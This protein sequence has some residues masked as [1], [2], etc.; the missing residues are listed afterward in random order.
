[1][2]GLLTR[3][4]V[5]TLLLASCTTL[6]GP[7]PPPVAQTTDDCDTSGTRVGADDWR[8]A[9]LRCD[10]STVAARSAIYR[11][12]Y[13]AIVSE[14]GLLD[15]FSLASAFAVAGF[16]LFGAHEDNLRAA[17]LG[18]GSST[19]MRNGLN[20]SEQA[21]IYNAGARSMNCYA[22]EA[23][24]VIDG[25]DAGDSGGMASTYA[26]L[27]ELVVQAGYATPGTPD[28]ENANAARAAELAR[29]DAL[30]ARANSVRAELLTAYSAL[31]RFP[32]AM[33]VSWQAADGHIHDRL[34]AQTP[35]I[36]A[37]IAAVRALDAPD[38]PSAPPDGTG[39]T[40]GERGLHEDGPPMGDILT[41]L[42]SEIS[43]AER[44]I[45]ADYPARVT[46]LGECLDFATP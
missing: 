13:V 20:Q 39:E 11:E 45:A 26:S 25:F 21:V 38:T 41:Q 10:M 34:T 2:R 4:C 5:P 40:G 46:R 9:R 35:D 28:P 24:A 30:V 42:A 6:N 15:R 14:R 12:R 19:V 7:P 32:N 33:S 31:R 8:A 16:G 18:L 43:A 36:A 29:R 23:M 44:Y 3:V 37:L 22:L 17:T 1:M 27:A